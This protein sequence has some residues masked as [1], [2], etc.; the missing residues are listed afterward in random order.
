M[1]DPIVA[2][3]VARVDAI[4]LAYG[5]ALFRELGWTKREAMT[6]ARFAYQAMN[7]R[8]MLSDAPP[9]KAQLDL[10]SYPLLPK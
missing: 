1:N 7:G 9:T 5:A 2:K 3:A 6:L 10:I 8:L 4:R